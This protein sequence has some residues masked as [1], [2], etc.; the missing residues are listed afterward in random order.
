MGKKQQPETPKTNIISLWEVAFN[1]LT[2]SYTILCTP[3]AL[4]F[5]YCNFAF[6]YEL[7][8]WL[9]ALLLQYTVYWIS[10]GQ[11]SPIIFST[12]VSNPP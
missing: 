3:L 2:M 9:Y 10:F 12:K 4:K 8:L 5:K 11:Y 6:L 1:K 7:S